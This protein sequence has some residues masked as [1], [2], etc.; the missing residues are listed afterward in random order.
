[1]PPG[2]LETAI[3][4]VVREIGQVCGEQSLIDEDAIT[5]NGSVEIPNGM[6]DRLRSQEWLNCW[7]IAAALEMADR[8]IY[9]KLGLSVPLH[10]EDT[11]GVIT[12]TLEPLHR[13]RKKIDEYRYKVN[14]DLEGPQVYICPL[15]VNTTHFTLL[16]INEQMKMIYHYDS[17]AGDGTFRR[18]AKSTLVRRVVEVSGFR[19][20]IRRPF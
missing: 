1:V 18:N 19:Q 3:D 12:P 4:R 5:I 6:F 20:I 11:N 13:W 16:E 7:D 14:H 10:K 17:M 8:P 9:V 15:N 2:C